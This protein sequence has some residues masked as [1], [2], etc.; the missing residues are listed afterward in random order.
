M[1]RGIYAR[2]PGM[3]RRHASAIALLNA[4]GVS[5]THLAKMFKCNKSTIG[6][7]IKH[8]KKFTSAEEV[9]KNAL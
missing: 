7:V 5:Y 6:R 4:G 2:K 8:F 9:V 1:P 3:V